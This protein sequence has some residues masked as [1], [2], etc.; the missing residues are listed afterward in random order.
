M[1]LPSRSALLT[2]R[3]ISICTAVSVQPQAPSIAIV[4]A[5]IFTGVPGTP[6]AEALT[7]TGD[8]IGVVGTTEAIRR[9]ATCWNLRTS[10]ER[11]GLASSS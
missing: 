10:L 3:V 2:V 1:T 5:R 11:R 9:T 6:W 4:N 8:R 7:V